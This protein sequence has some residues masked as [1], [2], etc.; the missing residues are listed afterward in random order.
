MLG[1]Y[2]FDDAVLRRRQ[3]NVL[4]DGK[5]ELYL[6]GVDETKGPEKGRHFFVSEAARC[7]GEV[8]GQERFF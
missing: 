3:R 5:R 2:G 1:S 7:H 8:A 6:E 4:S